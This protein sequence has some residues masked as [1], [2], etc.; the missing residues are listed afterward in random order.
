MR[1]YLKQAWKLLKQ[2]KLYSS[3]YIV[4]TGL[5]I[6]ITMVLAIIYYIKIAP[7]YPEVNRN[8]TL[9]V[10]SMHVKYLKRDN[11]S[12]SGLSYYTVKEYLYTLKTP[13][14]V[15]AILEKSEDFNEIELPN[16]EE[17]MTVSPLYIDHNFWNIFEFRFV[18]GKPFTEEEF[19]SGFHSAVIS[20]S[21]ANTLFGTI[22]AE[23]KRV[24]FNGNEYRVSGVVEDASMATPISFAQL[25]VPYT[26]YTEELANDVEYA[27]GYLGNFAAY[28]LAGSTSDIHRVKDEVDQVIQNINNT[29]DGYH[30]DISDQ[31]DVYWKSL[32]RISNGRPIN[33]GETLKP[34]IILVLGL[35]LIP[36]ANLAGMVSSRMEKRLSEMGLRK[37]FGASRSIL[38]R[39]ILMEN[40]FL[41]ILGGI[42]GL[43]FSYLIIFLNKTWILTIFDSW[44]AVSPTGMDMVLTFK[45]L[46]NPMVFLIA[47]IVC[48]LLN[49][50]SAV[51]PAFHSLKKNIIYSLNEKE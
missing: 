1:I 49:F 23:G 10:H 51:I 24:V 4:G 5:S 2:N 22:K 15:S 30:I 20:A 32:F 43:V 7:I 28:I 35:L 26:V 47:F 9:V 27:G 31:P 16:M 48:F 42:A 6:T 36:A 21:L 14:A 11:M 38:L 17:T 29:Q 44:P 40:L 3:V 25:W 13:R 8:H 50:L 39:Q 34:Y 19:Q 37:A 33:W 12:I 46:F 18:N 45:M 41:T